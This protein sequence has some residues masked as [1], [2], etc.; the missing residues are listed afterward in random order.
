MS[1]LP[2]PSFNYTVL[3]NEHDEDLIK[4]ALSLE[5]ASP[6]VIELATRLELRN[7]QLEKAN[8]ARAED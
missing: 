5:N 6:L 7:A 2:L 3:W 1:S 4:A 8:V